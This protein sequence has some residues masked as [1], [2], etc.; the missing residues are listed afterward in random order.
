M[1][2]RIE[3]R[4]TEV[5]NAGGTVNTE[6]SE[7]RGA[8]AGL[9]DSAEPA[10]AGNPGFAAGPKLVAFNTL[11]KGEISSTID[12]LSATADAIVASVE[13]IEQTDGQT[14]EGISRIASALN[15]LGKAPLPGQ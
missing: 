9:F 10:A 2:D 5:K 12:D 7:A 8:L 4:P 13:A 6:A 3:I 1:T 15:G 11:M 14:A